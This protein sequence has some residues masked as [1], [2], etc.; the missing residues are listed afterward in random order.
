MPQYKRIGYNPA[1][2]L[3]RI[4]LLAVI[5]LLPAWVNAQVHAV[6]SSQQTSGCTPFT[7]QFTNTS[8]NA[9]SYFWDF[10]NGNFST[11]VNPSNVYLNAGA[12]TVKLVAYGAGNS[13]DSVINT[14][15]IQVVNPPTPDFSAT[16]RTVCQS[17]NQ[18]AFTNL[19]SGY[20]SCL[21]DFG[22][23][24]TSSLNNPVHHYNAPGIYSVTLIAYN[25]TMGCFTT[26]A[27][28]NYITVNGTAAG[29]IGVN[30]TVTC[31]SNLVFHFTGS[32]AAT[33]LWNF[34]DATTAS[35][36]NPNHIYGHSGTFNVSLVTGNTQGCTDTVLLNTP[37][38]VKTNDKPNLTIVSTQGQCV[39][40]QVTFSS[41][42]QG[43][44][45]CV[46]NFG[47]ST[48]AFTPGPVSHYYNIG[49][50]TP[51]VTVSYPNGC[52]NADTLA[53]LSFYANPIPYFQVSA[54]QGCAPHQTTFTPFG[55]GTFSTFNWDFG[56]GTTSSQATPTHTY[57]GAGN[58]QVTLTTTNV[59]GCVNTTT[60]PQPVEVSS[61][62]AQFSAD[63]ITGCMP[64]NVNFTYP[65]HS[66]MTYAWDFGDGYTSTQ[67]SPSHTYNATGSFSVSLTVTEAS[68]CSAS[69][70]L[71][72]N[73][74]VTNGINN[75]NP[76]PVITACAPFTINLFD[77]SPAT[78]SWFWD[79]GDGTTSTDQNPTHTYM[80][81][82]TYDVS[83]TTQAT[84]S[85]CS[86]YVSPYRTYIIKGGVPD[87]TVSQ[88]ICPPYTATFT[89]QSVNAASWLWDFGDGDS[90]TLQ[91]PVHVYASAGHYNVTLTITTVDGCVYQK[92]HNYAV[93]FLP[94]QANATAT[95]TDTILPM[96]V[97]FFANS[98]GATMWFWDFGDGG[99]S[100]MMNP[101]HTYT[102]VGPYNVTLTIS[103]PGCTFTY[104]YNGVTIGSGAIIPGGPPDSTAVPDPVFNCIPYEMSFSNPIQ[105]TVSWLWDFGDG[106]TSTL[107]NPVHIFTVPGTFTIT[108]IAWD[109]LGN[110]DTIIQPDAINLVGATSDFDFNFL[111]TCQGSTI[112]PV[113]N[114]QN[115]VSYLWDFGD[116]TTS[117]QFAPTHVYSTS[118]VNYI[119]ALTVVDSGGCTDFM[120]RSYYAAVAGSISANV[121]KACANDTVTFNAGNLNFATYLW[122]FGDGNIST[123]TNP[124][125]IYADSGN[126]QVALTVTD[127]AGCTTTFQMPYLIRVN[128]PVADFTANV[129]INGCSP[130]TVQL[131]NQSSG[132]DSWYWNFGN[133]ITTSQ[134]HPNPSYALTAPGT[135][136]ITLIAYAGGCS[137]TITHPAVVTVPALNANFGYVQSSDCFPITVTYTDSSTDAVSWYWEFG[138]GTTST[139]QNPVHIFT[140]KPAGPV[141]L[142][143]FDA[144]G[145]MKTKQMQNIQSMVPA[146][147]FSDST[148]C[149]PFM[150]AVSDSSTGVASWNWNFGDG[151]FSSASHPQHVYTATGN[152]VVSLAAT[153]V[154]GCTQ[155]INP[156]AHITVTGPHTNFTSTTIVSCAPTVVNFSD[157]STG[158][159]NWN[160]DFGDG[161]LSVLQHPVHI[162]NQ[163]GNY[164][165]SLIISDSIGCSDTLNIPEMVHIT[166]SVAQFAVN[167]VSGCSPWQVSFQDSSISAFNWLWNFGDGTSSSS[168]NPVHVYT[169]PGS[170]VITL[171]THDTTGCQSVYSAPAPVQVL[172]PP[173][174][175][176]TTPDTVGCA[177]FTVTFTNQSQFGIN[178]I[179]DF[180]DNT[181]ASQNV[182]VHTYNQPGIYTVSLIAT[183]SN[184]CS[185][186]VTYQQMIKVG[187]MPQPG[188][189]SAVTQGCPPLYVQFNNNSSGTVAGTQ[190]NWNFGNGSSSSAGLPFV[191]YSQPGVYD[192]TLTATNPY[193]CA[194]SVTAS[195]YIQVTNNAPLAPV[196]LRSVSVLDTGKVEITWAPLASPLLSAY[197]LFRYNNY[198]AVY[199]LIYTDINP[200]N[201]TLNVN[202]TFVDSGLNT[203]EKSYTYVARAI[204]TC[205]IATPMSALSSHSTVNVDATQHQ[206]IVNV[207]WNGYGGCNV[208][209]YDISRQDALSG[210]Y[211]LLGTVDGNTLT[212][213]DST[214]YCD[215]LVAYRITANGL[216]GLPFNAYS[217]T[218]VV[219]APG[220]L[221]SQ[222]IEIVRSTVV[223]DNYILTEWGPPVL[224]PQTVTGYEIY[225]SDDG[226]TSYTLLDVVPAVQTSYADYEVD[227]HSQNYFYRVKVVN[228]CE[229]DAGLSNISTSIWLQTDIDDQNVS[230]LRWTRYE[231]WDSGVDYYVIERMDLFGNW[232]QIGTVPGNTT[233]Y[234]DR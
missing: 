132:A 48:N 141:R 213:T 224:L 86:Q 70:T 115:A 61:I 83:L 25:T 27:K 64:H 155:T 195:S 233:D 77:N 126:F 75:F 177:P 127:T 35:V 229:L 104:V 63:D 124:W 49:T 152:F 42:L 32:P 129:V 180:G 131:T 117:T 98:T 174:A 178:Y 52:I 1:A 227:V 139:L 175:A 226:G 99:T 215:L 169:T 81:P 45:G 40:S 43:T 176:F 232:K 146:F 191:T 112:I 151:S 111:N 23:G 19:S 94:L 3:R 123:Q 88:T 198:T 199:D 222:P 193:G 58:Y 91:H 185:D 128:K 200:G 67:M 125:H 168:Q 47:D 56:D 103:N 120:S 110:T 2:F 53:P 154:T 183:N 62:N 216:C 106:D 145:C 74:Q 159:G 122:D 187:S 197:E 29:T 57:T 212:Y 17:G 33:W 11:A 59:N 68:G 181:T 225:R 211:V 147:S 153:S 228:I 60:Y 6:F 39:P 204:N 214:I 217:D 119:I 208:D 165:V 164:D 31:D 188:F 171:I 14:G 134:Q 133:G 190:Y 50:F 100:S 167:A 95:T 143:V 96:N 206:G 109:A 220:M 10:G 184:G 136:S 135:Y 194:A 148:G 46:W 116:G 101:L 78:S 16:P 41:G 210:S 138:D 28:S 37:I 8:T 34:G 51:I 4:S 162:Y 113:N 158:A 201:S 21:W 36:Q 161:A 26:L 231:D 20:D 71:P 142:N 90:S 69:Y 196:Q 234:S 105:N 170:Y 230:K 9:S 72:F 87:F 157:Q 54:L 66:G 163:P 15:Y 5:A 173:V 12:Y 73:I 166:G 182:P 44:P 65:G 130:V 219:N 209:S 118:G 82:G 76:A 85:N 137:D 144:L 140:S 121:R 79:F 207:S 156:A 114:S 18:V 149:K 102:G 205:G 38:V 221:T 192:V 13:A 150:L 22:D 108:L 30:Q 218:V 186:T 172:Q 89:D 203:T 223:D 97:Q 179:W 93:T 107:E 55:L 80:T 24:V 189:T 202:D 7:V 84:G 160:W 92:V